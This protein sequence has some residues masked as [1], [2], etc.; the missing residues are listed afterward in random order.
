MD[1]KRVGAHTHVPRVMAGISIVGSSLTLL[2]IYRTRQSVHRGG[3][4]TT[5]GPSSSSVAPKKLSTYHR[6]LIGISV[7]DLLISAGLALGPVMQP[8]ETE[9]PGARGSTEACT[10]QGA[11]LQMGCASFL[12]SLML[13]LYYVLVIRFNKR[14]TWIRSK[15]EPWMHIIPILFY[16]S[17]AV[18]GAILEVFNPAVT[19]CWTAHYP[20]DCEGDPLV[21]CERGGDAVEFFGYWMVVYPLFAWDI[22]LV[23]SLFIVALTVCQKYLKSRRFVPEGTRGIMNTEKQA[24]QVIAQ[25]LLYS[26]AFVNT[27]VWGSMGTI[28]A[29]AGKQFET[30]GDHYWISC[31][32]VTFFP[33]QGLF[34]FLIFIRPRYLR[35]R[36]HLDDYGRLRSFWEAVWNPNATGSGGRSQTTLQAFSADQRSH[37]TLPG[38]A[39]PKVHPTNSKKHH[40]VDDNESIISTEE[41]RDSNNTDQSMSSSTTPKNT[42]EQDTLKQDIEFGVHLDEG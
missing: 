3:G 38:T 28:Y 5:R 6:L 4:V 27:M 42:A 31:L 26:L 30:F 35:N 14:E 25:A 34:N 21:E 33:L 36:E 22:L 11:L 39:S 40:H 19:H 23:L 2:T 1:S 17:T 18:A 41:A 10:F 20:P 13:M 32:A 8:P 29:L 12:Y 16:F 24:K 7:S 15:V 9:F 37:S